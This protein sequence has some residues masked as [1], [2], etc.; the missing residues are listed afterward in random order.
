MLY[1]EDKVTV[2]IQSLLK[3]FPT[4]LVEEL[5]GKIMCVRRSLILSEGVLI[6]V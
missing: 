6:V 5:S 1:L 3:L 4:L 2:L